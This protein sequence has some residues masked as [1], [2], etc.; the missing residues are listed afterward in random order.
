MISAPKGVPESV[1]DALSQ[2]WPPAVRFSVRGRTLVEFGN[3][4]SHASAGGVRKAWSPRS[5][6]LYC[7]RAV[8]GSCYA[9]IAGGRLL[10]QHYFITIIAITLL[11]GPW[12]SLELFC[13]FLA[14][15]SSKFHVRTSPGLCYCVR[16]RMSR[17]GPSQ[18][19]NGDDAEDAPYAYTLRLGELK[20]IFPM[21]CLEGKQRRAGAGRLWA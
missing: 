4:T 13:A 12:A 8:R 1:V 9:R 21:Q 15:G 5:W 18:G 6:F 7:V 20:A 19:A 14:I 16:R 3:R 2:V 10:T 17:S 11:C